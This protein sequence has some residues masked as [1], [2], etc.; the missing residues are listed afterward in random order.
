MRVLVVGATSRTGRHLVPAALARG[1]EVTLFCRDRAKVPAEH[2]DLPVFTGDSRRVDDLRPALAG[3]DAV[4]CVLAADSTGPT[5]LVSDS[6]RALVAAMRDA[7]VE[8]VVLCSARPVTAN[9]PGFV[10]VLLWLWLGHAYRDLIRAEGL[11]EGSGLDWRV[12]RPGRLSDA[13]GTGR[14]SREDDPYDASRAGTLARADLA[15]AM[16][17]LAESDATRTAWQLGGAA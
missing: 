8:R 12:A 13:P 1:H 14:Y 5:E 15:V 4:L 11:L 7:G 2:S 9:R 17:D 3:Q 16:L 6:M 10:L